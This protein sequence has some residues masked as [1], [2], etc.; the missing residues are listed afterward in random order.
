VP[1][2]TLACLLR[3]EDPKVAAAAAGGEWHA[4]PQGGVREGVESDW[5]GAMLKAPAYQHL[6]SDILRSDPTLAHDWLLRRVSEEWI[7]GDV[8]IE[9]TIEEALSTL[10][11]E[12]KLSILRSIRP[13]S[14]YHSLAATLV[15]DDLEL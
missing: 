15:G 4:N 9:P 13:G 3:H 1:E 2:E 10:D 5:Q 12:Q 7:L 14:M 11:Q 6:I 8:D